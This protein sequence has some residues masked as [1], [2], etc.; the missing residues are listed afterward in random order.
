MPQKNENMQQI[1][2]QCEL[3]VASIA[4][5]LAMKFIEKNRSTGHIIEIASLDRKFNGNGKNHVPSS[6]N[7][8]KK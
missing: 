6:D 3:S 5:H 7:E 8:V 2:M 1:D 4:G